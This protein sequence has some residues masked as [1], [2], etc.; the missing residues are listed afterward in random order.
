MA[1]TSPRPVV[2]NARAMSG[3]VTRA[4]AGIVA[5]DKTLRI[6]VESPGGALAPLG[7]VLSDRLLKR[8]IRFERE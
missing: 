1:A 2:D 8:T 6:T 5:F 7:A 3:A 4:T